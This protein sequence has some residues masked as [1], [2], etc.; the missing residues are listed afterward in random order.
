[1][2]LAA[3][4]WV[5]ALLGVS[6]PGWAETPSESAR[7]AFAQYE[8]YTG[9]FDP[10]IADLYAPDAVIVARRGGTTRMLNGEQWR[11]LIA[12][13]LPIAKARGDLDTFT[14]VA[15][16]PLPDGSVEVTATRVNHLKNYSSPYRAVLR[17][18][19]ERWLIAREEVQLQ[20]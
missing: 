20:P 1:M 16:R 4:A 8:T 18:A 7:A 11:Q 9:S 5:I 2:K 12:A 13:G 17:R 10:R 15:A 6:S 14:D 19:G 3:L